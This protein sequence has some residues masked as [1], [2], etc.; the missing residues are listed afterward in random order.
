M[1]TPAEQKKALGEIAKILK[2]VDELFSE[3][4]RIAVENTVEV[5]FEMRGRYEGYTFRPKGSE[6]DPW[7]DSGC[8]ASESNEGRRTTSKWTS[9]SDYC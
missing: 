4:E 3:A 2:Q 1:A 8:S 5:G 9:S 7:E 6:I